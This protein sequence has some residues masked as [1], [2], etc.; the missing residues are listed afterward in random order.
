[1]NI[2]TEPTFFNTTIQFG[3]LPTKVI[4]TF[5]KLATIPSVVNCEGWKC[6]NTVGTTITNF[7]N[8]ASLQNLK[9]LGDGFTTIANNTTIITNTGA[10]KLLGLNKVYRFTLFGSVWIEDA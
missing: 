2:I 1:M 6:I 7:I 5:T 4:G 8:G 9:I 3:I 10:N